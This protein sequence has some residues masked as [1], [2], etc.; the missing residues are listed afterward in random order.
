MLILQVRERVSG[1]VSRMPHRLVGKTQ[2]SNRRTNK[3]FRTNMTGTIKTLVASALLVSTFAIGTGATASAAGLSSVS[4]GN[5][6]ALYTLTNT[7][8]GNSVVAY[9]RAANGA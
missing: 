6:G 1:S 9:D 7:A 4:S 8:A 2:C 5:A 3:V